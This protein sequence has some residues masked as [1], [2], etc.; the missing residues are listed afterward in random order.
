[1]IYLAKREPIPREIKRE[2]FIE[3]NGE[4]V[5]CGWSLER[6]LEYHHIV[7]YRTIQ[8][9]ESY[10]LIP[11]CK[12]CH[13][14]LAND[15]LKLVDYKNRDRCSGILKSILRTFA[16]PDLPQIAKLRFIRRWAKRNTRS[17]GDISHILRVVK[18]LIFVEGSKYHTSVVS[19]YFKAGSDI[20]LNWT[21][22]YSE[23]ICG[24]SSQVNLPRLR[25]C[26][27]VGDEGECIK[28]CEFDAPPSD[29]DIIQASPETD[30]ANT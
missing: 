19:L 3:H 11:L 17:L 22:S 14:L 4:C 23:D 24:E 12:D 2:V 7:P 25:R 5:M 9:H 29:G 27:M 21:V 26:T 28:V 20:T 13:K 6:D 15:N 16:D 8:S 1:M 18:Y 30:D 10:N